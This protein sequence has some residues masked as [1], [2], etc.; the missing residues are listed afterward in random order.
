MSMFNSLA[1]NIID[2]NLFQWGPARLCGIRTYQSAGVLIHNSLYLPVIRLPIWIVPADIISSLWLSLS[3]SYPIWR[4]MAQAIRISSITRAVS[5]LLTASG[6]LIAS[7][8][9]IVLLRS[10]VYTLAPWWL[11]QAAG[12]L[13]AA[14]P[15]QLEEEEEAAARFPLT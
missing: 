7:L 2:C 3:H 9:S 8:R 14:C 11:E 12:G 5:W 15:P 6:L 10:T 4:R 1:L 13:P